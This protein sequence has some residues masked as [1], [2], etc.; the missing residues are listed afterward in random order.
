MICQGR[1]V[2]PVLL[3]EVQCVQ[4]D[5]VLESLSLALTVVIINTSQGKPTLFHSCVCNGCTEV[6]IQSFSGLN[7]RG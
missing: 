5:L 7:E 6:Q 3:D 4:D 2:Y 1:V